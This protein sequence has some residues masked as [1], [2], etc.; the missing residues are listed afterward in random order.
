MQ[1]GK[2]NGASIAT[3]SALAS[4]ESLYTL[5]APAAPVHRIAGSTQQPVYADRYS[6]AAQVPAW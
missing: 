2:E 6:N 4:K 5:D 1:R 3:G